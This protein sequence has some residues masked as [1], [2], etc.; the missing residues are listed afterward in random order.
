MNSL[1]INQIV[2]LRD[3]EEWHGPSK[4]IRLLWITVTAVTLAFLVY[5]MTHNDAIGENVL[6]HTVFYFHLCS[7]FYLVIWRIVKQ[8]TLELAKGTP[9]TLA[10]YILGDVKFVALSRSSSLSIGGLS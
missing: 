1:P 5:C 3:S 10:H 4:N 7:T 8:G 6:S 9:T 2:T